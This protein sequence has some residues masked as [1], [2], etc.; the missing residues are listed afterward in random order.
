MQPTYAPLVRLELA[1]EAFLMM[2]EIGI[3]DFWGP[4]KWAPATP[5]LQCIQVFRDF[6]MSF[7]LLQSQSSWFLPRDIPAYR[8]HWLVPFLLHF[9]SIISL[10]VCNTVLDHYLSE[11]SVNMFMTLSAFGCNSLNALCSESCIFLKNCS[12]MSPR[13]L[14]TNCDFKRCFSVSFRPLCMQLPKM[15]LMVLWWR[16][17]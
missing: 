2:E 7:P 5:P 3:T 1:I 9:L 15:L 10:L 16:G 4:C 17:N 11:V 8:G 13:T 6:G 12:C 14:Y